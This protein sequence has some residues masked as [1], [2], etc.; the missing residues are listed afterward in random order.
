MILGQ[1]PRRPHMLPASCETVEARRAL[2]DGVLDT[3]L[4]VRE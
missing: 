2:I 1:Q 4:A 3:V